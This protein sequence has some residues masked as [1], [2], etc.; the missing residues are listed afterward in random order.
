[1][2]FG[3][4]F[5]LFSSSLV[6]QKICN[7]SAVLCVVIYWS[8]KICKNWSRWMKL[9]ESDNTLKAPQI[10]LRLLLLLSVVCLTCIFF[11]NTAALAT[12]PKVKHPVFVKTV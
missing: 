1:M 9:S 3:V 6:L 10:L 2:H 7:D 12:F 11:R 5:F 4:I 8:T